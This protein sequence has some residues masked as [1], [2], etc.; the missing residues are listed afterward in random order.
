MSYKD[1]YEVARLYTDGDFLQRVGEQ[2]EGDYRL[3]FHLAPPLTANRNPTTGHLEKREYGPWMLTA[4]RVLARLKGLRGTVF[5]IFGRT[6]ERRAERRA[7]VEYETQLGDIA[8]T[9]TAA[10][11]AAAIELAALPLEIRGFGHVKEANR[12]RAAAKAEQLGERFRTAAGPHAI[13]AE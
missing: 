5:D 4:F 3:K 9:L 8:A 2:F 12:R 7:V 13:A 11:H 10:N 1:E 6:E